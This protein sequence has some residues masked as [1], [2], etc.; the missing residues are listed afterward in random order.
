MTRIHNLIPLLVLSLAASTLNAYGVKPTGNKSGHDNRY[1][2]NNQ[3]PP[4]QKVTIPTIDSSGLNAAKKEVA[5]ARADEKKAQNAYNQLH[6]KLEKGLDD[7]PEFVEATKKVT[8]AKAAYDKAAAPILKSLESSADYQAALNKT[9]AA[10]DAMTAMKANNDA[11]P[12]Q[13]LDAAKL[14]LDARNAVTKLKTD[15]LGKDAKVNAAKADYEAANAE[16]TRLHK[17]FDE[18]IKDNPDLAAAKQAWDD[19][20]TK[21]TDADDKLVDA[22]K[23]IAD[24]RAAREAAFAEQKKLDRE[25]AEQKNKMERENRR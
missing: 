15:A 6:A 8:L 1:N 16:V 21:T 2:T 18:S 22:N 25:Y 12:Q 14:S 13:R 17:E 7:K 3:L 5:A 23:N 4:R 10:D 20:K 19:A 11:T 9:K 24:Q